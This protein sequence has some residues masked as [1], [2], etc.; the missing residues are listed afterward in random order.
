MRLRIVARNMTAARHPFVA[1]GYDL[2]EGETLCVGF[3]D[4]EVVE[5]GR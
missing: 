1:V 2:H 5:F 4:V 3:D